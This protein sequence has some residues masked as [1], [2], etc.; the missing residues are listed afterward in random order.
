MGE[1]AKQVIWKIKIL[2]LKT[3]F[4]DIEIYDEESGDCVGF[5]P[6]ISKWDTSNVINI[7]NLFK[8]ST[9]IPN[10]LSWDVSS[11]KYIDNAF[12][13]ANLNQDITKWKMKNVN[14]IDRIFKK[15]RLRTMGIET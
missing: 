14:I 5:C 6:D 1:L 2:I 15:K 8:G 12:K 11:I 3:V 10:I 9:C 7:T 13:N 4:Q